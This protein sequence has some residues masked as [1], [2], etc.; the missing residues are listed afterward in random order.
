MD[1]P[2]IAMRMTVVSRALRALVPLSFVLAVPAAAQVDAP[3][4]TIAGATPQYA[5]PDDP[6]IYR[7][8]DIPV[9][10]EWLFGEL[11]NGLRYAVRNNGV[12]PGQVSIRVRIDAGS[13]YEQEGERGFAHLV[14]HLTFRQSKYLGNGE[15][16]P[17]FQ[18]LGASLGNDTNA[19]TS[20]TQTVY[21]LDLPNARPTVLDESMRLFSGMIR[22]PALSPANI[23][24]E[25][26]IVLAER[27]EMVGPQMRV[28]E[29][30]RS[31]IFTGQRL[32]E[33]DPIG[34]AETLQGA[35]SRTVKAFHDRWYRPENAVVVVVGDADPQQLAVLVEKYFGD[36]EGKGKHTPAPDFGDPVPPQGASGTLPV[37]ATDVLV[38]PSQPR[39]INY[40]ILRPW[41]EV[42]D[43][44]EYNR[45]LLIDSVAQAIVNRRLETRA[46]AGGN[47]LYAGIERDKPSR[48]A[49]A[50]F[51][52][53][54]PLTE[55]W[56]TALAD[57]RSVIA[58]AVATPPSQQEIDREL[59]ELDVAFANA[60]QQE[61][62]QAGSMLADTIVGA[63]DIREAV[64][65]PATILQVFREMRDRFTPDAVHEHTRALF[66][67]DVLRAVMV[68]PQPGEA[69][70]ASLKAAIEQDAGVG[71]YA[72]SVAEQIDFDQLPP[73][74]EAQAP[75]VREA[76]GQLYGR[77]VERQTYANGVRALLWRT[78][79]E[80][81]RVTVRVRFGGGYRSFAEDEGV[82]A[83]LGKMAL[84]SSGLGPLGQEEMD[85]L[86][87]GRKL[88][89]GFDIEEGTFTFQGITR[90]EDVADQLY[91]FAA[92]LSQPRWDAAPIERARAGAT[93][94][95]GS[96]ASSANGVATR[97]LDWLLHNRDPRFETPTP[98]QLRAATPEG[99]REVWSRILAE[100]PV[101]VDV[102]G[103]IDTA[104]VTEALSRTFGALPERG[105]LPP[106]VL[107]RRTSF[108][109]ANKQPLV[110]NHSGDPGQ[111][112]AIIAWPTG[113]GSE[114]LPESRKL[115]LLASLFSNRLLDEMRERTGSSY[116]PFVASN[117]PLDAP[118]GGNMLALA[119]L[120]PEQVP[121][122]YEAADAIAADLAQNGPTPDEL[123]R[124][125]EPVRQLVTRLQTGH[126]YWLNL[127]EGAAFD[128][129]RLLYVPTRL[130]DYTDTT[131]EE[132][133][134]LAQRY[135]V[136]HG[137]WRMAI[138]PETAAAAGR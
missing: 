6:W 81:G 104:A 94:S 5:Q 52:A 113:G 15:A 65:A 106:E 57:V 122:F 50:T 21:Q 76:V 44:L 93:M 138:L 96:Y 13:L 112:A 61:E 74:G 10:P 54:A 8:T 103:D 91:L 64:A 84:V 130:T 135:L 92:K 53:L 31:T 59:A 43:N 80:P 28:A 137:G 116:S 79:N 136:S 88:T 100:G 27:R 11:P 19:I 7:G 95:Y 132:I 118:D 49:D 26:P 66:E 99:F 77:D 123:A 125:M 17:H 24:T 124:A 45:G 9:D 75:T 37:G 3:T 72:R 127:I 109:E 121:A 51:V 38:E 111:A 119:Q 42:T 48:S 86:A 62:I 105:V 78:D 126:T 23:Q 131:P 35:T 56:R 58:D 34:T 98:D 60:A 102:F 68:T 114:K 12:P 85:S 120:T 22:E 110:R 20:P 117:W 129:N 108:P 2:L 1:T 18:R 36:W 67:G 40:A 134:E 4:L 87:T 30:M 25:V 97:D 47:Y 73:I 71:E 69:D 16:I 90:G 115:E 128:P 32:A 39:A 107:A 63:V 41:R 133:K 46:R 55:D 29:L 70:A 14:E 89:F 83:A 101:E 82:Y 33:R